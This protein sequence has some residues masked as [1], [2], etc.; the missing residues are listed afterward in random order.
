MGQFIL[1]FLA[2]SHYHPQYGNQSSYH[3]LDILRVI[4]PL[5]VVNLYPALG[6]THRVINGPTYNNTTGFRSLSI[7]LVNGLYHYSPP[8]P[9]VPSD[10]RVSWNNPMVGSLHGYHYLEF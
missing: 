2:N 3:R 9:S 6:Q 1:Y 10:G 7:R 8:S 4:V 5:V